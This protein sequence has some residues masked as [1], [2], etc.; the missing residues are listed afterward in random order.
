MK[1]VHNLNMHEIKFYVPI[2]NYVAENKTVLSMVDSDIV[3]GRGSRKNGD[4]FTAK[5]AP[6]AQA[7]RRGLRA[8]SAGKFVQF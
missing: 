8:C 7:S 5:R 1:K 4:R 2:E 6:K 3:K